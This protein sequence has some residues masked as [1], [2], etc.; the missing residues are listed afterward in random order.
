MG[1]RMPDWDE[2]E[3]E[4][5]NLNVWTPTSAMAEGT[6]PVL[7]WFHGGGFTNGACGWDWYDGTR[8]AALGDI[9]VV[10]ANYRHGPLGYLYLPDIGADN[11]GL[12]DQ[13]AALRWVRDNIAAFG[14]DPASITVGGQ[15]AGAYSA[16]ALALA[17]ETRDLVRRVIGQSGPWGMAPQEQANAAEIA[18]AYLCI[19]GIDSVADAGR[20]L[21]QLPVDR[22]LA[23]Y[24]QLLAAGPT[25]PGV[26]SPPMCPVLGG[27]GIPR[28]WR[29]AVNDG[30]LAC[31]E[32]L[33]GTTTDEATVLFASS[34]AS[35]GLT[36]DY[37]LGF[38][39]S[40]VGAD[41]AQ[42]YDRFA[43][44]Q[45][46]ATPA[47]IFADSVT[48]QLFGSGVVE[49]AA[50]SGRAYVYRFGRRP[51]DDEGKLGATHCADLPFLFNTFDFYP[52]APMLGAVDAHDRDLGRAFGGA[53][54][55][56]TATGSPNGPGLAP[57]GP[58]RPGP[59]PEVMHF[60]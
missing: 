27:A 53:L 19:L 11:L 47:R 22:L 13:T 16:L 54:A 50:S 57:W 20:E 59:A 6:R 30:D 29:E 24:R 10:T 26:L 7:L 60:R 44:R 38:L 31:S 43:T 37:V 49:I 18:A 56:F 39:T 51:P 17:P 55:A 15:S 25:R 12:Q 4:C 8:L 21:R 40:T 36:R 34:P 42:L 5:L 3:H 41:A 45:P 14:G 28:S 58:W 52:N 33:L 32:V 46:G 2:S 1:P 35:G 48:E 9:V 23:G